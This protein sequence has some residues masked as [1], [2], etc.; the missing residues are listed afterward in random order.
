MLE[1]L[2]AGSFIPHVGTAFRLSS[3]ALPAGLDFSLVSAT[4]VGESRRGGQV[5]ERAFSVI[6]LGPPGAPIL[7]QATYHLEHEAL[8]RLEIFLVPVGREGDRIQYEAVFN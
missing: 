5:R 6:F 4:P 1:T 7:P 2:T 3:S 8:G